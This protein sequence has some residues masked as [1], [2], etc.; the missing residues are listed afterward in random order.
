[1]ES[2]QIFVVLKIS[3]S[4]VLASSQLYMCCYLFGEMNIKVENIINLLYCFDQF[5]TNVF[6]FPV[7]REL[8][9]LGIYSCNWTE[10]NLQFKKLLLFSMRMN[11]ANRLM[12]KASPKRVINLQFYANVFITI[13]I[14]VLL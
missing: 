4:I 3:S 2:F 7:Q 12:L 11:N 1:M 6:F 8:V 14:A 13:E 9:N 10:M 5:F